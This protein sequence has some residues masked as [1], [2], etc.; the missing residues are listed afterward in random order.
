V[1]S[2]K[3][4]NEKV[5]LALCCPIVVEPKGYPFEVLLTE[6]SAPTAWVALADRVAS[7][8]WKGRQARYGGSIGEPFLSEALGKLGALLSQD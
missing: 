2:P 6:K 5:G 3:A 8:D 7:V 1:L 4:Y